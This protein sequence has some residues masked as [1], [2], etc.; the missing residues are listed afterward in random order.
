MLLI[1]FP[2]LTAAVFITALLV[3]RGVVLDG[4]QRPSGYF[5]AFLLICALQSMLIGTRHGYGVAALAPLL[6]VT[7][8]LIPPLAWASFARPNWHWKLA[9]HLL[10]SLCVAL[11][12]WLLPALIDVL[13]PVIFIAYAVQL[14]RMALGPEFRLS[15]VRLG[16]MLNGRRA[17]CLVAFTLLVSAL[18]D[19][20]IAVDFGLTDGRRLG[21]TLMLM[22]AASIT[23]LCLLLW[24][25]V[26]TASQ[27][28]GSDDAADAPSL[29]PA[30]SRPQ[31]FSDDFEQ[32]SRTV[33]DQKLY[34]DPA[35]NLLRLARKVGQPT[36]RVSQAVN[37]VQGENV[38]VWINN[39]R[40]EEAQR[41]L[42]DPARSVTEVI[43]ACGFNTK[44]SFNR[45]FKRV[46]GAPPSVWRRSQH[47]A[48]KA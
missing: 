1:P 39:L 6:P 26:P 12:W 40:I 13:V 8:L 22:Q 5:S 9:W 2:F 45:E 43:Y 34:L 44:S 30:T 10:P 31:D 24:S 7:G 47:R 19:I 20:V 15:W 32:V 25:S 37:A 3:L 29:A 28:S 23:A 16:H 17:L 11:A 36:R 48:G 42:D 38:S 14:L 46:T 33:R 35:L 18:S 27:H 4:G 21:Q 41:L